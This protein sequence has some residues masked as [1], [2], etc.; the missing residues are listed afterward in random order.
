MQ[1]SNICTD[2]DNID[3][4]CSQ[5]QQLKEQAVSSGQLSWAQLHLVMKNVSNFTAAIGRSLKTRFPEMNF[6]ELSV[7]QM[8]NIPGVI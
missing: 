3:Y 1:D 6:V 4:K 7:L 8:G 5:F 2:I